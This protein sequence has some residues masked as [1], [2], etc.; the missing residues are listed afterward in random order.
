M[1]RPGSVL[2]WVTRASWLASWVQPLMITT[3]TWGPGE[4]G[5]WGGGGE[6]ERERESARSRQAG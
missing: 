6:R 1:E 5:R 3:F 2:W 4:R